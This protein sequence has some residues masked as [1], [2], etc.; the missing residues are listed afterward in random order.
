MSKEAGKA[1]LNKILTPLLEKNKVYQTLKQDFRSMLDTDIHILDISSESLYSNVAYI[2]DSEDDEQAFFVGYEIFVEVLKTFTTVIP[3]QKTF[4]DMLREQTANIDT[5]LRGSKNGSIYIEEKHIIITS[6]FGSASRLLRQVTRHP[7]LVKDR[8]FG[9]VNR[10]RSL[11]ELRFQ[12]Y[13]GVEDKDNIASITEREAGISAYKTR[14]PGSTAKPTLRYFDE[15]GQELDPVTKQVRIRELSIFDIG[16]AFQGLSDRSRKSPLSSKLEASLKVRGNPSIRALVATALESLA[17]IQA[18]VD[19]TYNNTIPS[20]LLNG[21]GTLVLSL[22]VYNRNNDYARKE[23]A[24]YNKLIAR[25]R[26]EL[27][28][29][30]TPRQLSKI[31]G[32][33]TLEQDVV[34]VISNSMLV[35]LGAKNKIKPLKPHEPVIGKANTKRSKVRAK[36]SSRDTSLPKKSKSG[37]VPLKPTVSGTNLLSLQNLINQ[38]LQDVVSANMG[39]GNSRNV[40]N[41][42]TGRLA[43]SAKVESL[44]E[45]RAG[46]ITAFYSY[47]KNP[48]ATFSDG[49]KQSSPRSRDPKL[50]ISKSIR[51]IA[52]TQVGNRLR[53]VNI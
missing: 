40:L 52:A 23:G 25:M 19:Y 30:L 9:T 33:D 21:R 14:A 17:D 50:L 2:K 26:E 31:P 38:Q 35:T 24:I 10:A 51:E 49:G 20:K 34:S 27:I 29:S 1:Y 43:S 45:S 15:T 12:G 7:K 44:S 22:H 37:S 47:M 3:K 48:Y 11:G 41:Y 36:V 46:M 8:Y 42:R 5:L 13:E 53:A 28:S 16:H 4:Y 18:E 6:S 32:S 39:D